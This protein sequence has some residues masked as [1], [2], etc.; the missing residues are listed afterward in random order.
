MNDGYFSIQPLL[1]NMGKHPSD[2]RSTE[3]DDRTVRISIKESTRSRMKDA[4]PFDSTT[5]DELINEMI[6]QYETNR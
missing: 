1:L 6:H 5:Y 3:S 2:D 4:K